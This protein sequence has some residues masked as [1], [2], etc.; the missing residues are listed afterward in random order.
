MTSL[1]QLFNPY[2]FIKSFLIYTFYLTLAHDL[3]PFPYGIIVFACLIYL[4]RRRNAE[5]EQ[6]LTFHHSLSLWSEAFLY[7]RLAL[8]SNAVGNI[9]IAKVLLFVAMV[10]LNEVVTRLEREIWGGGAIELGQG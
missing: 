8:V 2:A 3:I 5:L 9:W 4:H 6:H 1:Q 7:I 10:A